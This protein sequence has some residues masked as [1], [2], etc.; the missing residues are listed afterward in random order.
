MRTFLKAFKIPEL[1]KKIFVVLGILLVF[2]LLAAI[3]V[4]GIDP[5]RLQGF[6]SGNQLLGF[7][8]IFS[9]GALAN[10]SVMMLGVG[11][12]ITATIIMQLLTMVFPR[13]KEIYYE[14]GATGRAKFNRIS[15]YLTVPLAALQAY[16]LLNLLT[17]QGV[18]PR[19]GFASVLQNVIVITAGSLILMWLG[20]LI[21][22]QKI[23]NGISLIIF[24]GIVSGIPQALQSIIFSYTPSLLTTYLIFLV[25]AVIVIAGVVFVTEGER[26]IPVIYSKRVRGNK[27]YG[28]ASSYL[29]LKVNQAGV[30][31]IIFAIS[32]LLFP[33][34]LAQIVALFAPD[35]SITLQG[36]VT[37]FSNN[38]AL[39]GIAYFALVVIFTYFY[40]SITF[41]PEEIAKNLQQSGGFVP[42]IR[43]GD[44]T[45]HFLKSTT[46]KIT[47]FGA[48]FLGL[49]A[50]LPIMTQGITNTKSLT[51]G[52]TALLIVVAVALETFRQ[53]QSQVSL[54][55]Y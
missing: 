14:E 16:G 53:I 21:T 34:F 46:A 39:Y 25:V 11:P 49:I 2:R 12:F 47:L 13:L 15:R 35:F 29:P 54:R 43:P 31:P 6:L 44:P 19:L 8:N 48:I 26:K 50:V 28:G 37:A 55:E 5:T 52:G 18:I 7:L 10:L 1:R 45:T 30:I 41:N 4:P 24:A 51:I 22:E 23:G 20:E 42:G 33:Q 27:M 9:G 32:L 38:F 40:T 17:N 36:W 3:P